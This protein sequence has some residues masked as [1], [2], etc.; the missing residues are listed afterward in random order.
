M[1]YAF[2][3]QLQKRAWQLAGILNL[4]C[5]LLF[6]SV[7]FL[8]SHLVWEVALSSV[9]VSLMVTEYTSEGPFQG[10]LLFCW[11]EIVF[12][13]LEGKAFKITQMQEKYHNVYFENKYS[14]GPY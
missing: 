14:F 8:W 11:S 6:I 3:H 9:S 13:K 1:F 5:S 12:L 10:A 4:Q 7:I 2:P